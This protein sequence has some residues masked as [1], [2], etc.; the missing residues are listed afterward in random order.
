MEDNVV[1]PMPNRPTIHTRKPRELIRL[2]SVRTL[3]ISLAL[4]LAAASVGCFS[5][6]PVTP[7]PGD[8]QAMSYDDA[9]KTISDEFRGSP[10][11]ILAVDHAQMKVGLGLIVTLRA[12]G[13]TEVVS[14]G[15]DPESGRTHAIPPSSVVIAKDFNNVKVFNFAEVTK[16]RIMRAPRGRSYVA[17]YGRGLRIEFEC[18]DLPHRTDGIGRAFLSLC[19]NA[20]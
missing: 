8:F 5:W 17:L 9:V 1:S 13:R 12:Q 7:S 19:P 4:S 10:Y 6:S 2:L 18:T 11:D 15:P 16:I 20:K 14:V 3:Y